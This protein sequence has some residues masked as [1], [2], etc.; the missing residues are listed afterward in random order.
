MAVSIPSNRYAT[1]S[2]GASTR[3]PRRVDTTWLGLIQ[4]RDGVIWVKADYQGGDTEW[5]NTT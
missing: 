2:G 5:S 1:L 3:L 4:S